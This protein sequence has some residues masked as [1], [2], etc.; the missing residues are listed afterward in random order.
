[1]NQHSG[2]IFDIQRMSIHDGPGIRTVVFLKGCPLK[3]LW[4]HN[5]EG[6]ITAIELF[7]TVSLCT[8]CGRCAEEC[9]AN[10]LALASNFS[11]QRDRERCLGCGQCAE[12]C[13]TGALKMIGR[14][15][16]VEEI[17]N[18]V[19]RDRIFYEESG[20]GLTVSGG[21]PLQQSDFA[22][23]LLKAAKENGIHTCLETCGFGDTQAL[24]D[25]AALTDIILFDWKESNPALHKQWTGVSNTRIKK[26]LAALNQQKTQIILR[27]P[28][29]P[30]LNLRQDHLEGIAKTAA[31]L[32]HCRAIHLMTFHN[33]GLSKYTALGKPMPE[34]MSNA[35]PADMNEMQQA[36]Q[37][38]SSLWDGKVEI[39]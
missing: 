35:I 27:C 6:M 34:L 36:Q 15:A 3:C 38:L 22:L 12:I 2:H 14:T 21:E 16:S 5:P 4:C 7:Y 25:L 20:G 24:L 19:L 31:S 9:S 17:M 28:L 32:P 1:M 13:P 10:A 29:V 37:V 11:L 18:E 30:G 39:Y 23:Q 8:Y 33:Y 26:N